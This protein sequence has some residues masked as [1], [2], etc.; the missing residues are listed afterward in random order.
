M[1]GDVFGDYCKTPEDLLALLGGR[2][3]YS[4]I[5]FEK[6]QQLQDIYRI[7]PQTF[8]AEQGGAVIYVLGSAVK[9]EGLDNLKFLFFDQFI[10]G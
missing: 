10:H 7:K 3:A 4:V 1:G 6:D 9:I 2:K 5:L 8:V